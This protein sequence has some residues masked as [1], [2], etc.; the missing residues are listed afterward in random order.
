MLKKRVANIILITICFSV[1]LFSACNGEIKNPDTF[2]I[3]ETA[4][5][6]SLDP[7]YGYDTASAGQIQNI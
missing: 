3:A 6:A 7:A 5:I 4:D 2:I 1:L